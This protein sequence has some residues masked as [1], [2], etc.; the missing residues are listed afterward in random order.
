MLE[1]AEYSLPPYLHELCHQHDAARLD[2]SAIKLHDVGIAT[3]GPGAS[4]AERQALNS[5]RGRG[6]PKGMR[7]W[8]WQ[9]SALSWTCLNSYKLHFSAQGSLRAPHLQN[10]KNAISSRNRCSKFFSFRVF[11]SKDGNFKPPQARPHLQNF[12]GAISSRNRSFKFF[13]GC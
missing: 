11:N 2:G 3:A 7:P 13:A 5:R 4:G 8:Y 12:V 10:F 1:Y 6:D 9:E